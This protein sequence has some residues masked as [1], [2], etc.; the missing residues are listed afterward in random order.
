MA[1]TD[2]YQGPRSPWVPAAIWMAG[3]VFVWAIC[4][5]GAMLTVGAI[6]ALPQPDQRFWVEAVSW[7][8]LLPIALG[9]GVAAVSAV[10]RKSPPAVTIRAAHAIL[11]PS[12]VL[13]FLWVPKAP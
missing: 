7:S 5:I 2:V 10:R 4:V 13:I 9:I 8:P 12:A 3:A 11:W 6:A 1:S